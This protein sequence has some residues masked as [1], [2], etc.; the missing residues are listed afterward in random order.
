MKQTSRFLIGAPSSGSGKTTLTIGLLKMLKNSNFNVQ[1]FKCGPDYIDTKFHTLASGNQTVNLDLYL[2][3]AGHVKQLYAK[4][5]AG[6]DVCVIEG[7]MGLFDG[8]DKQNGSSAQ[9]AELLDAPV[10]LVINAKAMAYSAAPLL[11]GFKNFWQDIKIAGAIFNF[12]GSESHY[13]FLKEACADVGIEPLGYLPKQQDIEISSRHLGLNFDNQQKL[14]TAIDNAA[15]LVE[16]Y[17]DV[18]KLL[19][20]TETQAIQP[21]PANA[22]SKGSLRIAVAKDEAFTF[23]YTENIAALERLGEVLFFSPIHDKRLPD[24]DFIY[25][26]GGYPELYLPQLSSNKEML[27]AIRTYIENGGKLL[28]ECGGMMHLCETIKDKDGVEYPMVGVFKQNASMYNTRMILGYRTFEYNNVKIK[29]HEFHYSHIEENDIPSVAKIY[30]ARGEEVNTKLL[31]YKNTIAGYTHIY[32][33][34]IDLMKLFSPQPPKG[35]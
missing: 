33:P 23:T 19:K 20:I 13:G 3:S 31:R 22:Y 25:L 16:K 2:S 29:G 8:Y 18:E 27:E 26:P 1:P 24:A 4:Y 21:L 12:V 5:G 30:N 15:M 9:I 14:N 11:Y 7:V 35:A 32:W 28:A 6:K 17:I 34:E 10:V